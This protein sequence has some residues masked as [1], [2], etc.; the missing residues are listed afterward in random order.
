[1]KDIFWEYYPLSKDE[2]AHIWEN[3]IFVFD[4]NILLNL[5][6]YSDETAKEFIETIQLLEDKV[7]LPYQVAQEFHKNRLDVI[8]NEVKSYD[9][10]LKKITEI[11][12][13]IIVKNRNPF[14]SKQLM[15]S[16]LE[17]QDNLISE[18][19][20]AKGKYKKTFS[21][22]DLT[23]LNLNLIFKDKIGEKFNEEKMTSLIREGEQRYK[24]DIPPGYKD[25]TKPVPEKFGDLIIWH[26][27]IEKSIT[28]KKPIVFIIDDRKEDWWY[29]NSGETISPRVELLRE[30]KEKTQQ[31]CH[32][33]K[34]FQFLEYSGHFLG[35][36]I[37]LD[38]LKEVDTLF[39]DLNQENEG[40]TIELVVKYLM[41]NT[42]VIRFVD[43]IKISGYNCN[44]KETEFNVIQILIIF[45]N[46]PDIERRFKDKY[47]SLLENYNLE[48]I[49]Y[50]KL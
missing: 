21:D 42:D 9:S 44:F 2:L 13:E 38:T 34:P 27:I 8:S 31:S 12:E 6:R 49:E 43:L 15:E 41:S 30:F 18:C 23:L 48:L 36:K 50:K 10:L 26:Q 16:F 22:E 47:L 45:P 37:K 5:Y 3:G 19:D 39:N 17:F 24:L 28:D 25:K 33:Y 11:Q 35:K 46:I 7:W 40:K 32:F 20:E 1:M 29:I 4:T 14:V